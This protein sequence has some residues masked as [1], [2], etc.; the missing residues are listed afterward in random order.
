MPS[1][2]DHIAAIVQ[3]CVDDGNT[4]ALLALRA[5]AREALEGDGSKTLTSV[6]L[7]AQSFS[8]AVQYS[9]IDW[10]ALLGEALKQ[11][12]ATIDESGANPPGNSTSYAQWSSFPH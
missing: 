4:T 8:W 12:N 10:Y 1:Q 6:S 11:Y 2:A 7:G 5:E 3:M 9:A